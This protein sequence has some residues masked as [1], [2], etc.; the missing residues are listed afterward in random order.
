MLLS[1]QKSILI[2]QVGLL[3]Y[4]KPDDLV[5]DPYL[6]GGPTANFC[7]SENEYRKFIAFDKNNRCVWEMNSSVI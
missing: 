7:L 5:L 3:K 4:R 2:M 6:G 1:E